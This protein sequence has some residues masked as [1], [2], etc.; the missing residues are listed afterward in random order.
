MLIHR[1]LW[2]FS[3][4]MCDIC[5]KI[6]VCDCVCL[7]MNT[8]APVCVYVYVYVCV[9]VCVCGI[10]RRECWHGHPTSSHHPSSAVATDAA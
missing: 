4:C 8:H 10:V 2:V 3:G 6:N 7:L 1:C 5:K 9:C